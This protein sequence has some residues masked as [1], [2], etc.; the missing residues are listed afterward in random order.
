VL[1]AAPARGTLLAECDQREGRT[2][3]AVRLFL[4]VADR[5]R[6]LPAAESALYA[7]ARL[8][9]RAAAGALLERYL[10]EHPGDR[11]G[12]PTKRDSGSRR[13]GALRAGEPVLL[14]VLQ[15]LAAAVRLRLSAGQRWAIRAAWARRL[16]TS[17]Q[18]TTL[19]QAWMKSARRFW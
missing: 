8:E 13:A 12:Y 1:L 4:R 6:G 16:E 11:R 14:G 9:T 5:F 7:A 17:V 10:R 2:A 3:H 15:R 18:L 19:H